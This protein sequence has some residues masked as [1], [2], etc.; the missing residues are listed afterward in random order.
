MFKVHYTNTN[1]I[2]RRSERSKLVEPRTLTSYY[3]YIHLSINE[4]LLFLINWSYLRF[5]FSETL[6]EM[7]KTHPQ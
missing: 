3:T 2:C 4:Y 6:V 5:L 7:H 1:F